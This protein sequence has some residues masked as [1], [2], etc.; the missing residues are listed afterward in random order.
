[1]F[2]PE[3]LGKPL[4]DTL[5][6]RSCGGSSCCRRHDSQGA[7][8]TNSACNNALLEKDNVTLDMEKLR[9]DTPNGHVDHEDGKDSSA[10]L[11]SE[12]WWY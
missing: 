9:K 2:L 3:T 5:P 6:P 12:L 8:D 11:V 4:P 10:A 7:G 1:M